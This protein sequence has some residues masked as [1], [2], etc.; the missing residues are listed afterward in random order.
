[1]QDGQT[2]SNDNKYSMSK[3]VNF[4]ENLVEQ[5]SECFSDIEKQRNSICTK[6]QPHNV[7]EQQRVVQSN[8]TNSLFHRFVFDTCC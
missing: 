1:M 5:L 2:V 6:H 4:T 3:L 8:T 7:Y